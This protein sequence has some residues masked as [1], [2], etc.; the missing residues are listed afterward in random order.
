MKKIILSLA[1]GFALGVGVISA[2]KSSEIA[3]LEAD[4]VKAEKEVAQLSRQLMSLKAKDSAPASKAAQRVA[5]KSSLGSL[6]PKSP[7]SKEQMLTQRKQAME[8]MRAQQKTN[9]QMLATE[10]DKHKV[11]TTKNG[12]VL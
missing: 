6:K 9:A 12:V 1:A 2:M 8:R 4:N 5:T 7:R 10:Q 11:K 3:Q